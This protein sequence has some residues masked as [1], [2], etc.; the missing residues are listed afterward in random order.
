MADLFDYLKIDTKE[1]IHTFCL[2]AFMEQ[3]SEFRKVSSG[4]WGFKGSNDYKAFRCSVTLGMETEN[5]RSKITPDLILCSE[6][7]IA[8]I[9]SKMYSTEGRGQTKDYKENTD[10]IRSSISGMTDIDLNNA[11]VQFY[12]FTLAGVS[13]SADG[14]IS[15]RWADYY[16]ETLSQVSFQDEYLD[17]IRKALLHRSEDYL[18]FEKFYKSRMYSELVNNKNNSWIGPYSLFTAGLL[19]NEWG[20]DVGENC[21]SYR[22]YNGRVNGSGHTTFRTDITDN[23]AWGKLGHTEEDNIWLF[24]RIEWNS[25]SI[26]MFLNWEYWKVTY[27]THE[28][29]DYI[30]FRNMSSGLKDQSKKNRSACCQDLTKFCT[31]GIKIPSNKDNML[32]MLKCHI[33]VES[34][35]IGELIEIIKCKLQIF[36]TAGQFINGKIKQGDRYLEF[37]VD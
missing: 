2:H 21:K 31:D 20:L 19:D 35:T 22:I 32:H 25:D 36:F 15:V 37:N 33:P 4:T 29:I 17:L 13:A 7:H 11:D 9:E 26:D 3:S 18:D 6:N 30:P 16:A 8:L 34:K 28:W 24:T 10:K 5:G 14:F 1:D 27:D 12:Y 23:S